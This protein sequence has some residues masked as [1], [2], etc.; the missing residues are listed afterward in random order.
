MHIDLNA[1]LYIK[2]N[3][4]FLIELKKKNYEIMGKK[5]ILNLNYYTN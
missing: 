2:F 5:I 4:L 1:N 3:A